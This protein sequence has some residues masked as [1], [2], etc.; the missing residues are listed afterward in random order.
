MRAISARRHGFWATLDPLDS[1][2]DK[3]VHREIVK[4]I[5]YII[6][7][8]AVLALSSAVSKHRL[9]YSHVAS[10]GTTVASSSGHVGGM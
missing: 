7:F 6:L 4:L 2:D 8:V 5:N 1:R 3:A 9:A 10:S